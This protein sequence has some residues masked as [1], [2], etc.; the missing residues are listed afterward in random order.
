MRRL[1][2]FAALILWLLI[3]IA[4]TEMCA[5]QAGV[6]R[7]HH[8]WGRFGKGAW[9]VSR[10]ATETLDDR[11]LVT[12]TTLTETRTTLESVDDTGITLKISVTLEVAGK[13]I[14]TEPQIVQQGF[15]GELLTA[16]SQLRT[17]GSERLIVDG[18]P[19]PCQVQQLETVTNG[20][21]SVTK[22]YYC[23]EV[24]PYVLR[25]ESTMLDGEEDA[26]LAQTV[27][28]VITLDLPYKILSRVRRTAHF[29]AVQET[30]KG[31]TI[32]MVV[33]SLEVPG[34]VV[35]QSTK[36]LDANDRPIRRSTMELVGYGGDID[37]HDLSSDPSELASQ[38]PKVGIIR[39]L[40]RVI[41]R[42]DR[43]SPMNDDQPLTAGHQ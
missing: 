6:P 11:G 29:K 23:D 40:N 5:A 20:K 36:E 14:E 18:Q 38:S 7:R 9:R 39:L 4:T 2:R 25:T 41:A 33:Q 26:R 37:S 21:R 27:T 30:P 22:T 13:R 15:N 17:V 10:V 42:D 34:G 16:N 31:K 12:D 19:Y 35:F 1:R 3:L 32:S 43:R 8:P 24:A 28:E